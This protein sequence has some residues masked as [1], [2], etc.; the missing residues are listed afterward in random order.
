MQVPCCNDIASEILPPCRCRLKAASAQT[1]T[2]TPQAGTTLVDI[3]GCPGARPAVPSACRKP[4]L[5][6]RDN[7]DIERLRD[8]ALFNP[9]SVLLD[10]PESCAD[11]CLRFPSCIAATWKESSAACPDAGPEFCCPECPFLYYRY[12]P[13]CPVMTGQGSDQT[14]ATERVILLCWKNKR[15]FWAGKVIFTGYY[16]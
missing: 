13:T 2:V 5:V 7:T 12:V 15:F 6:I 3:T 4:D 11:L 9:E 1:H 16:K 10:T 8:D 14:L